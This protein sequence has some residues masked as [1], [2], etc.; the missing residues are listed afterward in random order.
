[1][2]ALGTVLILNTLMVMVNTTVL[3]INSNVI[4]DVV[5]R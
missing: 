3:F 4:K 5:R 1:M 2:T